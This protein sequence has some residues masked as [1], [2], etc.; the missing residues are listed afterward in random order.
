MIGSVGILLIFLKET[1]GGVGSKF[2]II[3]VMVLVPLE[4]LLSVSVLLLG[5]NI[6]FCPPILFLGVGWD[7][8]ITHVVLFWFM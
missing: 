5:H 8:T 3:Y 2:V 1:G 4:Q 6:L 7:L